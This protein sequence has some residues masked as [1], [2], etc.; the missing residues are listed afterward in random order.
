MDIFSRKVVGSR[1]EEREADGLAVEMFQVAFG[2]HGIP[3]AATRS[4]AVVDLMASHG[5]AKTH[6]R[7]RVSNDNQFSESEFRT[8]KYRPGYSGTFGTIE[9]AKAHVD[10]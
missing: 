5:V 10:E 1:V 4:S 3:G 2:A 9:E 6:N 7:P 8:M